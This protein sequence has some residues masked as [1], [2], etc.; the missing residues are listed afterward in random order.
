MN[1]SQRARISFFLFFKVLNNSF[2]CECN[3]L[4][5][6]GALGGLG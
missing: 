4:V 2:S 1:V 5:E 3:F 6:F